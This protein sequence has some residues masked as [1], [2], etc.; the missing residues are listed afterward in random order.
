MPEDEPKTPESAETACPEVSAQVSQ[1]QKALDDLQKERD[2]LRDRLLRTAAELD[3]TVKRTRKN[4][5]ASELEVRT[6]LLRSFVPIADN[7]ERALEHAVD[8]DPVGLGVKLVR[9]QLMNVFEQHGIKRFF[10]IGEPFD[11]SREEAIDE[12]ETVEMPPGT[13]A[14]VFQ[15][16]YMLGDRVL[17]PA[18]VTVSKRP[19]APAPSTDTQHQP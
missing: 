7:L 4:A 14:N 3:N 16:G 5:A 10:P 13:V 1:L 19:V 6:N 2:A 15:P 11:P 12:T 9:L 17:R 18:L 8:D